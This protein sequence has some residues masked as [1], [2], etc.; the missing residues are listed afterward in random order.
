MDDVAR[1]LRSGNCRVSMLKHARPLALRSSQSVWLPLIVALVSAC[2][3]PPGTSPDDDDDDDDDDVPE[4]RES[5]LTP[6]ASPTGSSGNGVAGSGTAGNG[7]PP[8][9]G[10][11]EGNENPAFNGSGGTMAAASG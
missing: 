11:A 6:G 8:P 2:S 1:G 9:G 7:A 5:P 3:A 4:F 10:N